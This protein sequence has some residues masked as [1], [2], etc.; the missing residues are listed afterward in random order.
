MLQIEIP[1]VFS[2][3]R[4]IG[5]ILFLMS[6]LSC[7]FAQSAADKANK[8][9]NTTT[10]RTTAIEVDIEAEPEGNQVYENMQSLVSG[11]VVQTF[12]NRYQGI[13]GSPFWDDSWNPGSVKLESG[14]WVINIPLKYNSY[15]GQLVAWIDGQKK[16]VAPTF[17]PEF[18]IKYGKRIYKFQVR[19]LV[20][21]KSLVPHSYYQVLYEGET[22]LYF[23]PRKKLIEA[24]Y[25]G[26]YKVGNPYDEFKDAPYFFISKNGLTLE[27]IKMSK[28]SVLKVFQ[29][30]KDKLKPFIKKNKLKFNEPEDLRAVVEYYDRL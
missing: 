10:F 13:K 1:N 28:R 12:D 23:Q 16:T 21:P 22:S 17:I 5:T 18:E 4:V 2:T 15:E 20:P 6:I 30:K 27:E 14:D 7:L 29:D 9:V 19:K 26:A 25:E 24:D 8:E 11:N 3:M